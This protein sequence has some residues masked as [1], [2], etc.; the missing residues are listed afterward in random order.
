MRMRNK[1]LIFFSN[2]IS[3]GLTMISTREI[4]T[5]KCFVF[6]FKHNFSSIK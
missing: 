2:K 3:T 5:E 6:F 1:Y 4:Y